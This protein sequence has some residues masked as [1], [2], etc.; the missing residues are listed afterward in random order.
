MPRA[1]LLAALFA[2]PAAFH[3]DAALAQ[4]DERETAVENFR[5]ADADG[6]G[7]LTLS[8]FTNLIDLNAEDELGRARLIKRSGR[9]RMA[10]GRLDADGDARVTP[11]EI[12][13][14]AGG[15]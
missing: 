5:Q 8:E 2:A 6:D 14:V 10:F 4:T 12:A 11:E 3:A 15:S 13:A 1:L 7:A 9:Y